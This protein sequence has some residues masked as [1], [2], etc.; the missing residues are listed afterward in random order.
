MNLKQSLCRGNLNTS[1]IRKLKIRPVNFA[2]R[3]DPIPLDL[4]SPVG[5]E[6]FN[7]WVAV[8]REVF[9]L[10]GR[11]VPADSQDS[12]ND[13]RADKICCLLRWGMVGRA[14][15]RMENRRFLR[16][17]S[18][19]RL[20]GYPVFLGDTLRPCFNLVILLRL[21]KEVVSKDERSLL[22][23]NRLGQLWPGGAIC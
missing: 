8:A 10:L 6:L 17:D 4:P 3:H 21:V 20:G 13:G 2:W 5:H 14:H 19:R 16:D 11:E 12:F 23:Q 7:K 18:A 15:F 9:F 1:I 22:R